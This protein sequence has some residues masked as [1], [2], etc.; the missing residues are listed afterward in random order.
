MKGGAPAVFQRALQSIFLSNSS[1]GTIASGGTMNMFLSRRRWPRAHSRSK[2]TAHNREKEPEESRNAFYCGCVVFRDAKNEADTEAISIDRFLIK[3]E[4]EVLHYRCIMRHN[5]RKQ[6]L[7][8]MIVH[9]NRYAKL[10]ILLGKIRAVI[11][12]GV[13]DFCLCASACFLKHFKGH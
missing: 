2:V 5:S 4:T 7:Y 12:D 10:N 11:I 9:F 1:P 13:F 8:F 3:E 6:L